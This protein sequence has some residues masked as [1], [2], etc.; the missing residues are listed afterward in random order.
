MAFA[1]AC[2]F[3][4]A[5]VAR[6]GIVQREVPLHGLLFLDFLMVLDDLSNDEIQ[7][8][9][10]KLGVQIGP[11]CKIFE[12]GNLMRF[13]VRIGRGK[14]VGGFEL[15]HRLGVFKPLAQSVDEDRIKAINAFTVLF[16][17]FGGAGHNISQE[18]SLSV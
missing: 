17:H 4:C 11:F 13:A 16:E 6:L 14:V 5:D 9:L 15:A 8:I 12:P 7:E 2:I 10:G 1:L 18:R 3:G